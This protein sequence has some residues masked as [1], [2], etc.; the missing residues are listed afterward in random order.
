MSC[1]ECSVGVFGRRGV[2]GSEIGFGS[3]DQLFGLT[4]DILWRELKGDSRTGLPTLTTEKIVSI[5]EENIHILIL[6][7]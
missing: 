7:S 2:A 4:G 1:D 5:D 3:D 6:K